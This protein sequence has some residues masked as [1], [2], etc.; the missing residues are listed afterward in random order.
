[1]KKSS[2]L[3]MFIISLAIRANA[4]W[5]NVYFFNLPALMAVD[6]RDFNNGIAAGYT[7]DYDSH[8]IIIKTADNGT[9]WDTVLVTLS[10]VNFMDIVFVDT[11]TIVAVG[12]LDTNLTG[13]IARST[14]QGI[15]WDSTLVANSL[16]AVSFPSDSIGYAGGRNGY[17]YKTIDKGYSWTS[18]PTGTSATISSI[19]FINDTV[20]FAVQIDSIMKTTNGGVSW[21]SQSL[22]TFNYCSKVF[23]PSDSVGYLNLQYYSDTMKVYKTVDMGSSWSLTATTHSEEFL[24]N[25]FFANDSVGY[26]CGYFQVQKTIDGG[27][28]WVEQTSTGGFAPGAYFMDWIGDICFLNADTGFAVG[29]QVLYRT[30]VGGVAN[31]TSNFAVQFGISVYP[32][33]VTEHVT[34]DYPSNNAEGPYCVSIYTLQGQLLLQRRIRQGKTDIDLAGFDKGIYL[35]NITGGNVNETRKIIKE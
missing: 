18:I 6:F 23:F 4:Q 33:P 24:C 30:T 9:T 10:D 7:S 34:I 27:H 22:S 35:L 3:L 20:G 1:M 5:D 26:V 12:R 28:T 25:M 29:Y 32:N 16:E 8:G 31:L 14:D 13:M 11:T 17:I 15:T 19:F 21:I 2:I